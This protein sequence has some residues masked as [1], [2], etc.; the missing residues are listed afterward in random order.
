MLQIICMVSGAVL[1]SYFSY[2]S[3]SKPNSRNCTQPATTQTICS[4]TSASF[5]VVAT[6]TGLSYQWEKELHLTNGGSISGATYNFNINPTV[7]SDAASDYNV[8]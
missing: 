6:G 8:V 1:S 2:F 7:T 5:N 3:Y 4:G